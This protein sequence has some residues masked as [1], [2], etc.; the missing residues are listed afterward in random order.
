M[1]LTC[2][3]VSPTYSTNAGLSCK[4]ENGVA[5]NTTSPA[6]SGVESV[7][8]EAILAGSPSVGLPRTAVNAGRDVLAVHNNKATINL[9]FTLRSFLVLRL[10]IFFSDSAQAYLP[11]NVKADRISICCKARIRAAITS[12]RVQPRRTEQS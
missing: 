4:E 12:R 3:A 8:P 11:L 6:G 10:E 5:T 1:D 9:V 7:R 2:V